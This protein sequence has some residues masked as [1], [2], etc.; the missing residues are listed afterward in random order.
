MVRPQE[1]KALRGPCQHRSIV[2]ERGRLICA[3]CGLP[4]ARLQNGC[5]VVESKHS[6]ER[7]VNAISVEQLVRISQEEQGG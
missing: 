5:L 2:D 7:H 4:F 6:G 1:D 3:C